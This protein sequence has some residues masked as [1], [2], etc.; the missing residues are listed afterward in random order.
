MLGP[1]TCEYCGVP[2]S[3]MPVFDH[4]CDAMFRFVESKDPVNQWF[5][6]NN[7]L[8]EVKP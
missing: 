2:L 6:A 8:C 4:V 7:K 3:S 1:V 5:A